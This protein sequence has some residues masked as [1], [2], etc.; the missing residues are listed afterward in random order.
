MWGWAQASCVDAIDQWL[1]NLPDANR[2]QNVLEF[3]V[4]LSKD[5]GQL[6]NLHGFLKPHFGVKEPLRA[7][8]HFD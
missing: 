5:F 1:V 4:A 3:W 6:K 2:V 7:V 8:F